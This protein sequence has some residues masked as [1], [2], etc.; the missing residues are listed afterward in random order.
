MRMLAGR[1]LPENAFLILAVTGMLLSRLFPLISSD[2]LPGFHTYPLTRL[3]A[4][5]A[6]LISDGT[7]HGWDSSWN[8]G[9]PLFYSFPALPILPASLLVTSSFGTISSSL[10]LR[11]LI[12]AYALLFP[13]ILSHASRLLFGN[14]AGRSSLLVAL[15]YLFADPV[16]RKS[17]IGL[18][19]LIHEGDI[20]TFLGAISSVWALSEWHALKSISPASSLRRCVCALG[21]SFSCGAE[22]VFFTSIL[23]LAHTFLGGVPSQGR[24]RTLL[25][26]LTWSVACSL[27]TLVPLIAFRDYSSPLS[28]GLSDLRDPLFIL[29]DWQSPRVGILICAVYS[30][31][32][33]FRAGS[34]FLPSVAI[35]TFLILPRD[36]LPLSRSFEI[37]HHRFMAYILMVFTLL[38]ADGLAA[39]LSRLADALPRP[40]Y[41][42]AATPLILAPLLTAALSPLTGSFPDAVPG[43]H[44]VASWSYSDSL[45]ATRA[46][47]ALSKLLAQDTDVQGRIATM[48]SARAS[49][50]LG[51][52]YYLDTVLADSGYTCLFGGYE[53]GSPLGYTL[54]DI[55]SA[56][57][58]VADNT[59]SP[60]ADR[61]LPI[62]AALALMRR[63]NVS[64]L[65]TDDPQ[66]MAALPPDLLTASSDGYSL[67][68]L[69][70]AS[71]LITVP[72]LLPSEII[73]PFRSSTISWQDIC[74]MYVA[75]PNLQSFP[76]IKSDHD[77][78]S[79]STRTFSQ[80]GRL[81]T[82]IS[83]DSIDDPDDLRDLLKSLLNVGERI[84]LLNYP[85]TSVD[86][87]LVSLHPFETRGAGPY[88]L[89]STLHSLRESVPYLSPA[90]IDARHAT[91]VR[92]S[93]R[94]TLSLLASSPT[95]AMASLAFF[96]NWTVNNAL[97][98]MRPFHA[99]PGILFLVIPGGVSHLQ[100]RAG[101]PESASTVI[102][103]IAILC[104]PA[105]ILF[106]GRRQRPASRPQ[107]RRQPQADADLAEH[108]RTIAFRIFGR[109]YQIIFRRKQS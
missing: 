82:I 79:P 44:Y 42:G 21:I 45:E 29:L 88:Q 71:P 66:V 63:L 9:L 51:T 43:G 101:L 68:K 38:A 75:S 93:G 48:Q 30:M 17:G 94:D 91:L 83:P 33:H 61:R 28:T 8:C 16:W 31:A 87:R 52:P 35:A 18:P 89:L 70:N 100:F 77:V 69:D 74:S 7:V 85:F 47:N 23:L 99:A 73:A 80:F 59:A 12:L 105:A 103:L 109:S 95:P 15:L 24:G 55:R 102:S 5:L 98:E 36:L 90:P 58:S 81:A 64:H 65:I 4:L 2:A 39:L 104:I 72:S 56:F 40:R 78:A 6:E 108:S 10:A 86:P 11:L 26:A 37:Q 19:G 54:R 76:F 57:V 27:F 92:S 62:S 49:A 34:I 46:R 20:A 3:V 67:Y 14:A 1:K 41:L 25:L 60:S 84:L 53:A 107:R 96:P 97:G 22:S 13:I 32:R 50:Q 106:P